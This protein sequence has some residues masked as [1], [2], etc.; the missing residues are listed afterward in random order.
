M[1]TKMN[2][3]SIFVLDQES[4]YN[5]YVNKLGFKVHTDAAMGPGMGW[6]TVCPPEQPGL[7]ISLMAIAD[8][9]MFNAASAQT[10]RELVANGIFGFGVFECND[11]LAT[12]EELKAKAVEFTKSPKK[13]FYGFEALFKDDSGNWF[14]LG[15]K[16]EVLGRRYEI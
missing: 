9:M 16:N 5:F 6:L 13:E 1:I 4:A 7:E 14:S 8:G 2:H 11:L 12:Y 15:R 10:M 3:V